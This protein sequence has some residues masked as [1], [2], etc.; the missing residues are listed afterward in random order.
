MADRSVR[1]F[2]VP[3]AVAP[4][5]DAWASANH[6]GLSFVEPDG[7][8]HYQRGEGILTGQM[9]CVVRQSG[10]NVRIEAWIHARLLA[11]ISALFLIP[12]DMS[13][14][15]GGMKGSLPRKICRDAVNKLLAQLGQPPIEQAT[16]SAGRPAVAYPSG[17]PAVSQAPSISPSWPVSGGT[18]QPGQPWSGVAG[19]YG[20]LPA[21]SNAM[22]GSVAGAVRPSGITIL[23]MVE[24]VIALVGLYV[25][26]DL[27]YWSDWGFSYDNVRQGV[28]DGVVALAYLATS[29]TGFVVAWRLWCLRP[30]AWSTAIVL[31]SA[32][33]GLD[34]LAIFLW[35]VETTDLLGIAVHLTVIWYLN[36]NHVRALFGRPP[37]SFMQSPS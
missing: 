11:R 20:S 34:V 24:V 7:S 5:A 16:V 8:R 30:A 36:L 4:A 13:V 14:E 10:P 17:T 32:L 28:V 3:F 23:A 33:I 22:D 31:S 25:A 9:F 37:M 2:Q 15:P 1:D 21:G 35:G 12:T 18:P 29:I 19:P 27:A 6:F 26:R